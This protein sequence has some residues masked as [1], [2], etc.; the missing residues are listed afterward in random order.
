VSFAS[1]F[2]PMSQKDQKKLL[3][4]VAPYARQLMYYKP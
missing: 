3:E 4:F 2:S 1:S